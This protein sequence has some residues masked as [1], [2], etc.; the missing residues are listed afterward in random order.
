[1]RVSDSESVRPDNGTANN[2]DTEE[3][4]LPDKS[5]ISTDPTALYLH[6]MGASELLTAEEEVILAKQI[7][8]GV[9]A[10]EK[11]RNNLALSE[12]EERELRRLK[13]TGED[14]RARF[15]RSNTRLVVSIAKQF[16]DQGLQ[17]LDLIQEGN[18]GLIKAVEEFDHTMGNRFSTYATYWIRQ[19]IMRAIDNKSR[20]IRLPGHIRSQLYKLYQAMQHLEQELGHKPTPEEVADYLHQSPEDVR[21]LMRYG[22]LPTS[23]QKRVGEDSETELADLIADDSSEQLL[24]TVSKQMLAEDVEALLEKLPEREAEVLRLRFGLRDGKPRTLKAIADRFQVSRERIR[25]IEKRALRRL[26][27]ARSGARHL[28]QY[29]RR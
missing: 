15:I 17:F 26:R 24:E 1:M 3:F 27:S 8:A 11:L 23:L 22:R 18:L 6:D 19:S 21:Q 12:E 13:Q 10:A 7:K 9:E 28:T 5:A 16:R 2:I 29:L 25:Q 20:T 4:V 14:A